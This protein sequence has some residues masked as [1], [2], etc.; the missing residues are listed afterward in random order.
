MSELYIQEVI[1]LIN[2]K[3]KEEI[4]KEVLEYHP[5]EVSEALLEMSLEERTKFYK[6]FKGHDISEII[7]YLDIDDTLRLFEEMKPR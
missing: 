7:S 5:Y 3:S 6:V 1:N 2:N 4:Y